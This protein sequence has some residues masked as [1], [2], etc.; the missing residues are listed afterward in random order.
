MATL[1]DVNQIQISY[2]CVV[3]HNAAFVCKATV[4]VAGIIAKKHF[5]NVHETWVS[6]ILC[7]LVYLFST[8][9]NTTQMKVSSLGSFCT[10]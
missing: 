8:L 2:A 7:R 3:S 1:G 5:A 6:F 10:K 9:G 4:T